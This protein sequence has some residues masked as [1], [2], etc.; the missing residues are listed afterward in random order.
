MNARVSRGI[1]V[2]EVFE[3]LRVRVLVYL[4]GFRLFRTMILCSCVEKYDRLL[5]WLHENQHL[6]EVRQAI[7]L[8]K[9]ELLRKVD[10]Y[11]YCVTQEQELECFC[12]LSNE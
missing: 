7:F 1:L 6:D 9:N 10:E 2:R 12:K 11:D 3:T 4:K 5:W 8:T